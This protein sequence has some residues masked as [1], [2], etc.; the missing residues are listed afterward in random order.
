MDRPAGMG[1][2]TQSDVARRAGVSRGLVSQV[3]SGVDRATPEVRERVREAA[4]ELGYRINSAAAQLSSR[5]SGIIALAVPTL[6]DPVHQEIF[7]GV[8]DAC[9][10]GGHTVMLAVIGEHDPRSE[11]TIDR[12]LGLVPEGIV[13]VDPALSDE[14]VREMTRLVPTVA[15]G[16]TIPGVTSVRVDEAAAARDVVRHLRERRFERIVYVTSP[17]SEEEPGSG[18]RRAAFGRAVREAGLAPEFLLCAAEDAAEIRSMTADSDHRIA[19]AVYDDVLAVEA[20]SVARESSR[21][22]V[23]DDIA[24]VSFTDSPLAAH[25]RAALSAIGYSPRHMGERAVEALLEDAGTTDGAVTVPHRLIVRE[26]SAG[27]A[28]S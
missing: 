26:S 16:R 14:A 28:S 20:L 21:R 10:R 13:L 11:R 19:F 23:G 22:V 18:E 12:L 4:R 17:W 2:P 5:R 1:R 8:A 6:G 24:M 27:P 3:F 25:P 7:E 9:D 15:T